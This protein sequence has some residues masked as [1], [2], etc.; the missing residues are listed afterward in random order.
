MQSVKIEINCCSKIII[1]ELFRSIA[2]YP[3]AHRIH[4]KRLL[5]HAVFQVIIDEVRNAIISTVKASGGRK[6]DLVVDRIAELRAGA[7]AV[8]GKKNQE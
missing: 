7:G 2:I 3:V 6:V 4:D 1:G 8:T 5:A